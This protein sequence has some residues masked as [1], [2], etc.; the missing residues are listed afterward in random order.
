MDGL[1]YVF[2]LLLDTFS[3]TLFGMFLFTILFGIIGLLVWIVTSTKGNV[4]HVHSQR[5][6]DFENSSEL[7]DLHRVY[8]QQFAINICLTNGTI[9]IKHRK[10]SAYALLY[11]RWNECSHEKLA[12]GIEDSIKFLL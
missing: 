11:P 1:H 2:Y 3:E 6:L 8:T 7:H 12:K 9:E 4:E 5:I 10:N